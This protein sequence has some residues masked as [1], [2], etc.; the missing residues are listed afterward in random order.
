M[1]TSDADTDLN[2][3]DCLTSAVSREELDI[4]KGMHE[5]VLFVAQQKFNKA[6]L[7]HSELEK[8]YSSAMDFAKNDHISYQIINSIL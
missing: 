3:L 2:A 5:R 8:L 1:C 6:A 7:L 4:I